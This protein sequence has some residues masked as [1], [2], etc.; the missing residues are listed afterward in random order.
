[1]SKLSRFRSSRIAST[2]GAG[3]HI[4]SPQKAAPKRKG[5]YQLATTALDRETKRRRL[6]EE[7]AILSTPPTP[8][9]PIVENSSSSDMTAEGLGVP[10]QPSGDTEEVDGWEDI[11]DSKGHDPAS[12]G[13]STVLGKDSTT[14]QKRLCPNEAAFALHSRW[15]DLLPTLV[16]PLLGYVSGSI[17]KP[18]C[19]I[20]QDL[21]GSCV[22]PSKR[23]S[24]KTT[25]I[26]CLY[27]DRE[28][29]PLFFPFFI[30]DMSY[31]PR[32]YYHQPRQLRM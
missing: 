31:T 18:L 7:L 9:N 15:K 24:T 19:P 13:A 26:L 12:V 11:E 5:R 20:E 22:R 8:P 28:S 23:C 1:M 32:L 6:L 2:T 3:L 30:L 4:V 21:V 27:F 29:D 14:K 17:C 25:K 16:D 10:E